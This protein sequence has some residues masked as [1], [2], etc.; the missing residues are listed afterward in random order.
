M[1]I[2]QM[3]T[4]IDMVMIKHQL[5]QTLGGNIVLRYIK[6]NNDLEIRIKVKEIV[7]KVGKFLPQ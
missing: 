4:L 3:L 1:R 2:S 6:I 5:D 7:F